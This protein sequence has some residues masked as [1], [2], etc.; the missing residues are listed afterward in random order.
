MVRLAERADLE[1]FATFHMK[2]H[3]DA[4]GTEIIA[5]IRRVVGQPSPKVRAFPWW[6]LAL[7]SPFV[8]LFRELREMRYLWDVPVRM[9]NARLV[10]L[11]GSEPHTPIDEAVRTTLEGLGCLREAGRDTTLK[12]P[13]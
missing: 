4:D 11:L 8:P 2:G 9:N 7:A 1:T 6:V 3:W 5:A 12:T 13:L 10:K